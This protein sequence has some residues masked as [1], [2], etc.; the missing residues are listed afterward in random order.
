MCLPA[1][2]CRY[3]RAW[4][5]ST[6]EDMP[7]LAEVQR[8]C[9]LLDREQIG[10]SEFLTMFT[11]QVALDIGCTRACVRILLDDSATRVLRCV[12]MYEPAGERL[13]QAPDIDC[14]G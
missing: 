13:L 9:G 6:I 5:A 4:P 12:A 11:R 14:S 8:I 7:D 3:P 1:S 2:S 10:R